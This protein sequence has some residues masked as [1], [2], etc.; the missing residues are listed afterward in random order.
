VEL[1]LIARS[2]MSPTSRGTAIGGGCVGHG[3]TIVSMVVTVVVVCSVT[4]VRQVVGQMVTTPGI[5][6]A[7][8]VT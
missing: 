1:G 6:V 3:G 4:T 7:Q 8:L 2:W 5:P